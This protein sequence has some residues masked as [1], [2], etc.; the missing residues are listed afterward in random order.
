MC[1]MGAEKSREEMAAVGG[2]GCG[3]QLAEVTDSGMEPCD[4]RAP[5]GGCKA[6]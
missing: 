6:H 5:E 2:R 4:Q 3:R 1:L